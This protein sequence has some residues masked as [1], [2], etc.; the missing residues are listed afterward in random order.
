VALSIGAR[1][2]PSITRAPV[3]A[4]VDGGCCAGVVTDRRATAALATNKE[5]DFMA[6]L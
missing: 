5:V 2:V 1:S 4:V 3:K 6:T